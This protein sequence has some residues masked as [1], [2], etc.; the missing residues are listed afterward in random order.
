MEPK[1]EEP[2]AKEAKHEAG[3]GE[4]TK[5]V[6]QDDH[7][8]EHKPNMEEQ[9]AEP[10]LMES[11]AYSEPKDEEA[12]AEEAKAEAEANEEREE[13]KPMLVESIVLDSGQGAVGTDEGQEQ[14]SSSAQGVGRRHNKT[15]RGEGG[16]G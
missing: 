11:I 16:R 5:E 6:E 14:A 8:A 13:P 7:E 12:K 15:P 9:E 3:Q 4:G 1:D 2:K 10:K